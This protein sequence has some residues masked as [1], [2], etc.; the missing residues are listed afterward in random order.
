P[1]GTV[2][3]SGSELDKRW[4]VENSGTCNWGRGYTLR[5]INE[6]NMGAP[7]IQ[8]L[9]PARAGTETTI[10]IIYTAPEESGIY[11]SAWQAYDPQ[12][13]PFGDPIFIEIVV[14]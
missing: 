5:L 7:A 3:F 10:R 11:R 4:L 1:E 9:F 8:S 6:P 2:V 12:E 13:Q 14:Q